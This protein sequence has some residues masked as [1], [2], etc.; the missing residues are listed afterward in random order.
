MSLLLLLAG[1]GAPPATLFTTRVAGGAVRLRA[2]WCPT[3]G[4]L[5][6]PAESEWVDFGGAMREG[7]EVTTQIGRAD[8]V[9]QFAVGSLGAVLLSEI[10][11]DDPATPIYDPDNADGPFYGNLK[12]LRQTRWQAQID[13]ATFGQP[14]DLTT[15]DLWRG[16]VDGWPQD[17]S[18]DDRPRSVPLEA[19]DA[20]GLLSQQELFRSVFTLDSPGEDVLDVS[21]LAPGDGGAL[22][23]HLTG[24]R[25]TLLLDAADWPSALRSIDPGL[26]VMNGHMPAGKTWAALTDVE[27]AEDGFVFVDGAGKITF[28]DRSAPWLDDRLRTVQTTFSDADEAVAF[29]GRRTKHDLDY[30]RNVIEITAGTGAPGVA[31]DDQ[32]I[33]DYFERADSRSIDTDDFYFA[34]DLATVEL[35]RSSEVQTRLPDLE[36]R[37]LRKPE[38]WLPVVLNLRIL[39]LVAV[40]RQGV[41][42]HMWVQGIRHRFSFGDWVTTLN[43]TPTRTDDVF[44]LDD[45]GRDTLDLT[46]LAY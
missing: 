35:D 29:T 11:P 19:H 13:W 12:P 30:V 38:V 5:E 34:Q 31:R 42:R 7:S 1:G 18:V 39:D 23:S 22:E 17:E 28:R 46:P 40:V 21:R 36:L 15:F 10:D 41:T 32:S 45:L 4:P 27:A 43:L 26:T 33:A 9:S 3:R 6:V 14:E 8:E 37:P 25:A 24:E 2:Q 16:Y 44:I 20:I